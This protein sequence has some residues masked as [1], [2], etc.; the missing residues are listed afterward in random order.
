MNARR[1]QTFGDPD[2]V[3]FR[4]DDARLL[5]AVAQRDV[6]KLY[7][8]RK[9]KLLPH[10]IREVPGADVPFIG[11]PGFL[12]HELCV[13]WFF[14]FMLLT[15]FRGACPV[16]TRATSSAALVCRSTRDSSE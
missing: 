15:G 3:V 12:R 2:L 10:R 11:F 1:S 9:M 13:P 5:L 4:E 8:S 7:L 14:Y 6:V 16:R